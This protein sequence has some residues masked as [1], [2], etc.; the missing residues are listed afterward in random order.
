M[1]YVGIEISKLQF[2]VA[3]IMAT[4]DIKQLLEG[5]FNVPAT[6]L[7]CIIYTIRAVEKM[8]VFWLVL[9]QS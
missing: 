5:S 6:V 9:I 3:S 1:G 2:S 7:E 4:K 8:Y